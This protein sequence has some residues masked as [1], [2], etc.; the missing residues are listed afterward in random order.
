MLLP[1]QLP[2][3]TKLPGAPFLPAARSACERRRALEQVKTPNEAVTVAGAGRRAA[4]ESGAR[5][6]SIAGKEWNMS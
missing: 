3:G 4:S 1:A 5:G 6:P 2:R